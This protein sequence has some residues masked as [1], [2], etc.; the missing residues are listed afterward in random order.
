[1]ASVVTNNL[2]EL[3]SEQFDE[4]PE[5]QRDRQEAAEKALEE[6]D[7][8][9]KKRKRGGRVKVRAEWAYAREPRDGEPPRNIHHHRLFYC[10]QKTKGPSKHQIHVEPSED[11]PKKRAKVGIDTQLRQQAAAQQGRDIAQ[12]RCLKEV[13][14]AN[15]PQIEEA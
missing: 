3:N 2:S 5:A 10:G 1:M 12:E 14:Q 7:E 15:K 8:S 13:I 9:G 6:I 11:D 4:L